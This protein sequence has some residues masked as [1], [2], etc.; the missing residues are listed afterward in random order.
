MIQAQKETYISFKDA[1]I[2]HAYILW[3]CMRNAY[4]NDKILDPNQL[5][6]LWKL[7]TESSR[8]S[9]CAVSFPL[10]IG[11]WQ[12][13][14]RECSKP[15]GTSRKPTTKMVI[16]TFENE[17]HSLFTDPPWMKVFKTTYD[18]LY[19][20]LMKVPMKDWMLEIFGSNIIVPRCCS[21]YRSWEWEW[22][23]P[24]R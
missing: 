22:G 12:L 14:E 23:W 24:Q 6:I 21:H 5:F 7:I 15:W 3:A 16:A 19:D 18:S 2:M 10:R 9:R 8:D 20:H 17:A 11:H 4:S 1:C 13:K